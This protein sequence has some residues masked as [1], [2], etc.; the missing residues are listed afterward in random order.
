[1]L[2]SRPL[3]VA[4]TTEP[5]ALIVVAVAGRRRGHTRAGRALVDSMATKVVVRDESI[6]EIVPMRPVRRARSAS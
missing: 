1:V 2:A 5:H 4:G 3:L 6:R